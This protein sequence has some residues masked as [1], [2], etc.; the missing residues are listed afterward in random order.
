[1]DIFMSESFWM[2]FISGV[3]IFISVLIIVEVEKRNRE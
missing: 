2:G 3:G 1:M